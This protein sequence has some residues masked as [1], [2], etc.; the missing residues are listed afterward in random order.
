M[1]LSDAVA[2]EAVA[3]RLAPVATEL[4]RALEL[5]REAAMRDADIRSLDTL[6]DDA[7]AYVHSNGVEDTKARYLADLSR[8]AIV[9]RALSLED[10]CVRAASD[11]VLV[12][13]GIM[14]ASIRKVTGDIDVCSRYTA[15]WQRHPVNSDWRLMLFQGTK[16]TA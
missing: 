8:G 16:T 15:V 1:A 7:L 14:V 9:Y 3:P 6:L 2:Q 10:I 5:R 13:T 4:A 11:D 12:L